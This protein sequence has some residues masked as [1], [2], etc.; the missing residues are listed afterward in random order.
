MGLTVELSISETPVHVLDEDRLTLGADM[1]VP[2]RLFARL[3]HPRQRLDGRAN[4]TLSF[5]CQTH[6]AISSIGV[7]SK[8]QG[9]STHHLGKGRIER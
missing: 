9:R 6:E 7:L 5:E 1:D 4:L 3:M 8:V 2:N